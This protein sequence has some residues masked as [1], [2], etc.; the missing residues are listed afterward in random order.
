MSVRRSVEKHA[1]LMRAWRN[2]GAGP[3]PCGTSGSGAA[4]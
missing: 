4:T 3:E 2:R 1:F